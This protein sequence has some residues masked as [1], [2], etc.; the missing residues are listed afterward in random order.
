MAR[1]MAVEEGLLVGISCGAA[2]H[3]SRIV[4]HLCLACAVRACV[5]CGCIPRCTGHCSCSL[6]L[7]MEKLLKTRMDSCHPGRYA[8]CPGS[9]IQD[10]PAQAVYCLSVSSWLWCHRWHTGRRMKAS[11]W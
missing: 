9:D 1:R 5:A 8:Y 7:F 6:I 3:A 11:R 2:A 4:C 10:L